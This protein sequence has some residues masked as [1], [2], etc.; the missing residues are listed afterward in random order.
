MTNELH[1]IKPAQA[2]GNTAS[3]NP[4]PM[5]N[6][7]VI[8]AGSRGT[9]VLELLHR[10][11]SI[12]I[13][14]IIDRDPLAPGLQRARELRIPISENLT[15]LIAHREVNLIVDVTGDPE[16]GR[17]LATHKGS[18]AE[19]VSATVFRLFWTLAQ[20]ETRLPQ[21]QHPVD[22]LTDIA[23]FAAARIA[24]D[25]NNPL[26]LILGLAEHLLNEQDHNVVREHTKGIIEAVKRTSA[27]CCDL[28]RNARRSS[29]PTDSVV[30]LNSQLDESLKIARYAAGF[31]DITVIKQYTHGAMVQGNPEEVLHVFVNL[32]VNGVHSM[33][34]SGG[35]LTLTTS[36]SGTETA[37]RIT[38]TGCGIDPETAGRMFEPFFTTKKVGKGAGLG[39]CN[40]QTTVGKMRGIIAVESKTGHGTTFTLTF[41]A[42]ALAETNLAT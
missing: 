39:L 15:M 9:A 8:G 41:P 11:P 36:K 5:I 40:V 38:D 26:Q 21:D 6:L 25:I 12:N 4:V 16:M 19:I 30:C 34:H 2:D 28:T 7:A 42:N 37:V 10:I 33:D 31:Q 13:V 29:V 35:T 3:T 1:T 22:K 32:I 27:M 20:H 24:H 17:Y 18:T 14:G 23:L